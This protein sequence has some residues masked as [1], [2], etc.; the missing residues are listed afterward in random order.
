MGNISIDDLREIGR[1]KG[2]MSTGKYALRTDLIRVIQL[3]D[4][5]EPCF[6]SD[7]KCQNGFCMWVEECA[8]AHM[9][10]SA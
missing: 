3:A 9:A 6:K 10:A 8:P 7:E 4:G 1:A 2:I 5:C